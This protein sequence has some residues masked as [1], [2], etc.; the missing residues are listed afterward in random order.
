MRPSLVNKLE[1]KIEKN[2]KKKYFFGGAPQ[3]QKLNYD[4]DSC[5]RPNKTQILSEFRVFRT[6]FTESTNC[7]KKW[8]KARLFLNLL[9]NAPK[10][11]A[12]KLTSLNNHDSYATYVT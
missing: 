4:H 8:P 10:K 3:V 6:I 9:K 1:L 7:P 11:I 5:V 2:F 12:S